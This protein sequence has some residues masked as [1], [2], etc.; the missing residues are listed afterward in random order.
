MKSMNRPPRAGA[1]FAALCAGG[2]LAFA[3]A[4]PERMGDKIAFTSISEDGKK[5]EVVVMKLD[6]SE[7]TTLTKE[8]V[9]E[10][11]PALSSDGKH[12]AF[13]VVGKDDMK[14]DLWVMG[15]DGAG[16]KQLT[17]NQAKTIVL[18]PAWS[19]DGKRIAFTRMT[20]QGG[21]PT[22][23][24]LVVVDA[25]GKNEKSVGKGMMAAWSPDGKR[26]LFAA[27]EPGKG[28][29]PRLTVM[30]AD[31]NNPTQLFKTPS[32][33]G[34]FSPDGRRIA[35]IGA[36]NTTD[37]QP[38]IYVA[39]AD[40]SQAAQVTPQSDAFEVGPLWSVDGKRIVFSRAPDAKNGPPKK[41]SLVIMDAD[42][43]NE[44]ELTKGDVLDLT[45]GAALFLLD[46]ADLRSP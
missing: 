38:H 32:M 13:V 40:G 42:G 28:F 44:K 24:E 5:A 45:G 41:T 4:P 30:D 1:V 6:G 23:A 21:P 25:D 26:I 15:A 39:N 16:R 10:I 18:S 9:L 17:E 12:I 2:A 20:A 35:Y 8:G 11:D 22:D 43:K 36:P 7:R 29:E 27:L 46:W 31:G 14:G 19:P 34:T 3:P 33:M 37:K